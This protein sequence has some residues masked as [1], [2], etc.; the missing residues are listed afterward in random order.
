MLESDVATGQLRASGIK[1][2]RGRSDLAALKSSGETGVVRARREVVVSAGA[3]CSPWLLMLSGNV[4]CRVWVLTCE[5]V[6]ITC[7]DM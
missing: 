4:R 6:L 5:S 1:F 3:Y 7:A 2:K